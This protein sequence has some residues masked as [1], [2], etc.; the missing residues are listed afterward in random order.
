MTDFLRMAYPELAARLGRLPLATLP[1]PLAEGTIELPGGQR[2]PVLIKRDDVAGDSYGGNK[3]RKLEFVLQKARDRGLPRVATFGTVASNHALAT[4][5]YAAAEGFGCTVFLSHQSR[6]PKAPVALNLHLK[7]GSKIVCFAGTRAQRIATLREH[8]AD[9]DTWIIPM[10]GS[11]WLGVLGFVAAGLELAAQL[12]A[13]GLAAPARV[14]V[15]N[16]TMGTAAGL[17]LGI[18]LAGL[19]TEVHA[20]R[21]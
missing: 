16:G 1:T 10:G 11:S 12:E 19:E 20:V 7:L 3:V 4:S 6:T 14:Y 18:A 15:A 17:A 5:I 8:L 2:T 9:R 13:A 21:V